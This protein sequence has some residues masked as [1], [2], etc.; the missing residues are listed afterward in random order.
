MFFIHR[1]PFPIMFSVI[2][3]GPGLIHLTNSA[4]LQCSAKTTNASARL[5]HAETIARRCVILHPTFIY[6]PAYMYN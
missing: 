3:S 4:N 5:T 6:L 1:L 2:S